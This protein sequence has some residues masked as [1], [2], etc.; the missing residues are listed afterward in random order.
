M[1][2]RDFSSR[3]PVLI[4]LLINV[5]PVVAQ[6]SQLD[7]RE[8]VIGKNTE[9]KVLDQQEVHAYSIQM[10]RDQ[11]LRV[12]FRE[13]G[14]DVTAVIVRVSNEQ[15]V[16]AVTNFGSGFMEES[17]TL[18]A[19]QD[20][21]YALVVRAERVT[22]INVEGRYEYS[23]SLKNV[24]TDDDRRRVNAERL[25]EEGSRL[26]EGNDRNGLI[27]AVSKF[28]ESLRTWQTLA[29]KYWA[30][31]VRGSL[32]NAFFKLGDFGKAELYLKQVLKTFEES[33]NDPAIAAMSIN[34]GGLYVA[35][36]DMKAATPY[37]S[38]AFEISKRLGDKRAE[39]LLGLLGVANVGAADAVG[40]AK[41][42]DFDRELA[43]ARAKNDKLTEALLWARTLFHY[44]VEEDSIK[45]EDQ[46]VLFERAER[47]AI[48]LMKSVKNRDI[49]S[50]ILVALGIGFYDLTL[51]LNSGE[52]A[53]RDNKAK[54]M[55]YVRQ[56]IIL[57]KAQNNSLIQ[58]LAYNQLNLFY[59]GDNDRLAIFFGKKAVSSLQGLRQDLK[60]I[61]RESQQDVARKLEEAYGSLAE[62]LFNEGRFAE[63]HQLINF[64]RDQEFFDFQRVANENPIGLTLTSRESENEELLN[65]AVQRIVTKYSTVP[66][67]DYQAAGNE[68]KI[69]LDRLEQNFNSSPSARDTSSNVPDTSDLQSAL[70]EL[71]AKTGRKFAA[72]YL[73]ADIDQ[74]LLITPEGIS[75][76]TSGP[77]K[78]EDLSTYVPA[79]QADEYILDFLE[80]LRSP[81]LDPRPLGARIYNT[82]FKTRQVLNGNTT[83]VTLENR[84]ARYQPDVL[85]W[86][87]TGNVRYVPVAALY[88]LERKQYLVEK[89]QNA[90][91]TR[92]RKERFLGEPKPWTRGVGFGTSVAY[93]GFR[94]LPDVPNELSAIFGDVATKQSGFFKGQVFLDRAFT[95]MS[96]LAIQQIKPVLIHIASHFRFQPGDSQNSFLLLGDGNKFSLFDLQHSPNLF[97]GVDLLTLS[98]CETAAQQSGANGREVDAFA[99][100]A[101]RLG[102]SSVL[103]TLWPISDEGTSKLMTEFY[104]L[105]RE[106]ASIPKSEVLQRAQLNLL[107]GKSSAEDRRRQAS[108]A[109]VAMKN[110][111]DRIQFEPSVDAPYEHPFYWA[112]F[113]LF[114]SSR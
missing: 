105:R 82:I 63:A 13:R 27:L 11:A 77:L 32:G 72:I 39:S 108:S 16:S 74:L 80:T 58:S 83:D 40:A 23:A 51:G 55:N 96:F 94:Q 62:D 64:G 26:L 111:K 73:F 15:K 66:D 91:F 78:T 49:E 18:I 29:D 65:S 9:R 93:P 112:P 45:D 52:R 88:D 33:K 14:A 12:N 60:L 103:A 92:A 87:L 46:R 41:G 95:R 102:A 4:A 97:A 10:K 38:R 21:V 42:H 67:S 107:Y 75:G 28:E 90:V 98:A 3:A 35:H 59:D 7:L 47:E 44:V 2:N 31:I 24:A 22:D 100:L 56:A 25:M 50:Q 5:M 79:G 57:A 20:G 19:D 34:L 85:L 71:S 81:N 68:L 84:L 89:Y 114:G 1:S 43:S 76:F 109:A 70:R 36:Q 61:D 6:Q 104:R 113:V 110:A 69:T 86:S 99:E 8:L 30:E 54:S 37:L 17:L 48:P 106:D 101:Q 53:D